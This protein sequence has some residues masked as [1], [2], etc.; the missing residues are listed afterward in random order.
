VSG[1]RAIV[2]AAAHEMREQTFPRPRTS[3]SDGLLE[4]EANGICGTDVHFR[5]SCQDVPRILGH[6]VVGRIVELGD[7]ARA[8]WGVEVGDR[9]AVEAGVTCGTCRDCLR[10]FSQTCTARLGYGSNVTTDVAPALWGGLAELMYLAPGTILTKLP[11]AVPPDAAAGWFS[12][13]ANA[14]DWTGSAGGD[15]QPGD[16]VV[17]LG[18]GP[19]GLSACLVAKTRGASLVVLAGLARDARRLDA[20]RALGADRT[21]RVDEESLEAVVGEAT[22]GELADV[23]VDVSGHPPNANLAPRLLRR[24]GTVVAASPI[25]ADSDVGLPL[26]EM[27]W[28][29]IRWQGVLS[30][31]PSAAPAAAELLAR[32]AD[33]FTA[34]VTHRYELSDSDAAIDAVAGTDPDNFPIKAVVC[35]NGIA[36]GASP[37]R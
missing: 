19:Q 26:R 31:R 27:I 10:G 22:D 16:A 20:G 4:V 6:E 3:A 17:I 29:Q 32:H 30:N 11:D 12:P 15:V 28:K 35:P 1:V 37:D 25:N 2:L 23:V 13:L 8:R 9:V 5:A 34:L 7:V 14:V 36:G 33:T 21:V 24:R 18:P